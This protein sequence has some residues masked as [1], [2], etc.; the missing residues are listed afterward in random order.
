LGKQNKERGAQKT[1]R[2]APTLDPGS[3]STQ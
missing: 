3:A 1:E 2:H